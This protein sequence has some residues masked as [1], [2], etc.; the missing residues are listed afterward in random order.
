MEKAIAVRY[1][2]DAPKVVAKAEGIMVNKL[3]EIAGHYDIPLYRAPD[4]AEA[5]SA[6]PTDTAIPEGLF[7]AVAEVIAHC[8]RINEKLKTKIDSVGF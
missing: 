6:I 8:Y 2:K 3:V 4:L 1:E 5:L 7:Q